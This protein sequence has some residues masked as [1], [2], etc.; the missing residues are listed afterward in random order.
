MWKLPILTS[1]AY[2]HDHLTGSLIEHND[3]VALTIDSG[4]FTAYQMGKPIVL[5]DYCRWL[6]ELKTSLVLDHYITLD[7]IG[8]PVETRRNTFR[9]M[10][11]GLK[12][13]PVFTRGA[14]ADDMETY[15]KECYNVVCIGGLVGTPN[16]REHLKQVMD[17]MVKG[18][19]VHWLGFTDTDFVRYFKPTSCD[20]SSWLGGRRFGTMYL[21]TLA[22]IKGISKQ[23][24]LKKKGGQMIRRGM[25]KLGYDPSEFYS[26]EAWRGGSSHLHRL[27]TDAFVYN[28]WQV[29]SQIGTKLYLALNSKLDFLQTVSSY[30]RLKKKGVIK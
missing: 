13:M 14:K 23:D 20:S 16:N 9:M 5:G 19:K 7:V 10:K 4:A 22:G 24:F 6:K 28:S 3:I 30:K 1:F 18:R 2:A 12:P 8:D 27:N 26:A 11:K 29:E 25:K 15:Y 21:P 17:T